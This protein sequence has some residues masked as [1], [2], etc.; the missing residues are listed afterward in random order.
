[1]RYPP[2][3]SALK[4]DLEDTGLVDRRE[5]LLGTT[6]FVCATYCMISPEKFLDRGSVQ[7]CSIISM[8][9]QKN[10]QPFTD[11]HYECT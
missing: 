8:L 4:L 9:I 3:S 2:R 11:W 10:L 1:M 5:P 7:S 6:L